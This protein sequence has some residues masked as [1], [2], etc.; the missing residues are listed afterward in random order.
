M[1]AGGSGFIG[2]ALIAEFVG[3]GSEVVV[4]SRSESRNSEV[5]TV[6]WDGR[7]I[8]AW[9]RELVGASLVV[10]LSGASISQVWT[11]AAKKEILLS[12]VEST[13][14]IGAALAECERPP[15][16][17]INSSAIGFYGDSG[18]FEVSEASPAGQGFLAETCAAWEAAVDEFDSPV[19]KVKMRTGVVLGRGG[20]A[21]EQL[22][23]LTRLFMGGAS[24]NG[25]QFISWIHLRDLVALYGWAAR[26]GAIVGPVNAVSPNPVTNEAF[27]R[28][29]RAAV[30]R[31]W[32]PPAPAAF[33]RLGARLAGTEGELVLISQRV[34]PQIAEAHDFPFAFPA[35]R[36]AL[37]D[38]V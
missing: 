38:L 28:E 15:P 10:N 4:L 6:A 31:P 17:W 11:D 21:L 35:L 1:I 25:R 13:R 9:A 19:R 8:G 33:V 22:I 26:E 16:V 24:G 32:S 36:E 14:A 37:A 5:R 20:G 23:R 3:A 18:P 27:M 30:G 7:R 2:R 29:L 34:F 12:R